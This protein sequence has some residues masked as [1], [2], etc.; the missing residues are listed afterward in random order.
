M[1][2][3]AEHHI[4]GVWDACPGWVS[5]K[6][7]GVRFAGQYGH[8]SHVVGARHACLIITGYNIPSP[9]QLTGRQVLALLCHMAL[10]DRGVL[11]P[12]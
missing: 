11:M 4:G 8:P 7:N 12:K 6:W 2:S 3:D 5:G 9:A 1:M 10:R